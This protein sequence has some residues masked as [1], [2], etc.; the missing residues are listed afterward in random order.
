MNG[1]FKRLLMYIFSS[2]IVLAF[3]SL[4]INFH[5]PMSFLDMLPGFIVIFASSVLASSVCAALVKTERWWA[6]LVPQILSICIMQLV[7]YV[8]T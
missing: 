2:F 5:G 4:V 6:V 7:Y 8:I 1:F 3:A